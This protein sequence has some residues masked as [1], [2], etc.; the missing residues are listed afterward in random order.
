[1]DS[2]YVSFDAGTGFSHY[3]IIYLKLMTVHKMGI[4]KNLYFYPFLNEAA[5]N[6]RRQQELHWKTKAIYRSDTKQRMAPYNWVLY[7]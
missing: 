2:Y 3:V 6:L 1:M 4:F 7:I 5:Q